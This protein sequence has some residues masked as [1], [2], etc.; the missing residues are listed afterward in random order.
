MIFEHRNLK[1]NYKSTFKG[2]LGNLKLKLITKYE[3]KNILKCKFEGKL[4]I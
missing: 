4:K 2:R 1:D 3:I